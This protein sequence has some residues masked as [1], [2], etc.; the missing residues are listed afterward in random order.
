MRSKLKALMAA[1]AIGA[2]PIG[3]QPAQAQVYYTINGQPAA[4]AIALMMAQR[5]L[6][7]RAPSTWWACGACAEAS[8]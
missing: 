8:G 4:P 5:R 6:V 1:T 3:V 7:P 2:I